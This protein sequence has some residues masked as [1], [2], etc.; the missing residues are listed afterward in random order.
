MK[1][2]TKKDNFIQE[3]KATNNNNCGIHR[4]QVIMEYSG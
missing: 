1:T 3:P 4:K 2:A